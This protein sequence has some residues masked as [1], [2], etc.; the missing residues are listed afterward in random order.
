[1]LGPMTASPLVSASLEIRNQNPYS[2]LADV[3]SPHADWATNLWQRTVTYPRVP[4]HHKDNSRPVLG[5]STTSDEK[6]CNILEDLKHKWEDN[7]KKCL[8]G[9]Q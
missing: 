2:K 8:K 4:A 5:L 1:M 3:C 9:P 6:Y 7:I